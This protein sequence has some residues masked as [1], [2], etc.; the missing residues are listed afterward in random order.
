[1]H[2]FNWCE[3]HHGYLGFILFAFGL[4]FMIDDYI[5]HKTGKS[6]LHSAYSIIYHR[7]EWVRRV[8]EWF[9]NLFGKK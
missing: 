8:N 7:Y 2:E 6:F 9:D 5:F 4:W 1:M 3:W